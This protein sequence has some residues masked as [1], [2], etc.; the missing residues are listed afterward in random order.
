MELRGKSQSV[1]YTEELTT[2][3]V[4][5]LVGINTDYRALIVKLLPY[6]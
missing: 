6:T 2:R 3:V 5:V 4:W 1:Y